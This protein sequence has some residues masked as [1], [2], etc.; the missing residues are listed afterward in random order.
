MTWNIIYGPY[1]ASHVIWVPFCQNGK[2]NAPSGNTR[3]RVDTPLSHEM[4][5]VNNQILHN[6][7]YKPIEFIFSLGSSNWAYVL[8]ITLETLNININS[9]RNIVFSGIL[10]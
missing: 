9:P 5:N 2:N 6:G 3:S 8:I 4:H 1:S 10:L 7:V